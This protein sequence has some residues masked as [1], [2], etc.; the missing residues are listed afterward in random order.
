[1]LFLIWKATLRHLTGI[2]EHWW[3]GYGL[4]KLLIV[5]R[6]AILRRLY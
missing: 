6:V 2:A 4:L 3:L 5:D 1:L